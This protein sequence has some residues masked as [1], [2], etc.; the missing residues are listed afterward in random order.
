MAGRAWRESSARTAA[1]CGER[2]G[3]GERLADEVE[4]SEE[5]EMQLAE[6]IKEIELEG[7]DA[8][9]LLE[10]YEAAELAPAKETVGV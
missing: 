4:T 9:Q 1:G 2:A 6:L 7:H 5:A 3:A 10:L 8:D